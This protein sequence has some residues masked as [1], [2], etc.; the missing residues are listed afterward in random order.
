MNKNL[1]FPLLLVGFSSAVYLASQYAADSSNSSDY[2]DQGNVSE[3]F[4]YASDQS[5]MK[6]ESSGLNNINASTVLTTADILQLKTFRF[7]SVDGQLAQD[8]DGHLI[9]NRD[10]RHWIDFYLSAIGE[11]SLEQVLAILSL[12][13]I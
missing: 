2:A 7:A 11:L 6:G 10:L 12:I 3:E 5:E 9:V 4:G 13:H 8:K 1:I